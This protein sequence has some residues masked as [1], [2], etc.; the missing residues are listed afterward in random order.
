MDTDPEFESIAL[1]PPRRLGRLLT[2]ARATAGFTLEDV[3]LRCGPAISLS[4]LASIERGTRVVDDR[5]LQVLVDAYGLA[6][7]SLV[8]PR[9]RLIV[10]LD[11]GILEVDGR[12]EPIGPVDV[13]R[14]E[15]LS[16]YLT[17][18][19]SMR[20]TTPG[21]PVPLRVEDLE[22]LGRVLRTGPGA[23]QAD[24]EALMSRSGPVSQ[25][26]GLLSRKVLV[27]AAGVLVALLGAGAL[28]LV[29]GSAATAQG[30]TGAATTTTTSVTANASSTDPGVRIGTAAVQSRQP[31]GAPGPV[32]ERTGPDVGS[33]G[34][35]TGTD[36]PVRLIPPATLER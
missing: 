1:V 20:E 12:R 19:Y 34:L 17:L 3:A 16:R 13:S 28:V 14:D 11:G 6:S 21:R 7:Q 33:G 15:V 22:T 36:V 23:I 32:V 30:N 18:V 27:P 35:V 8:P 5:E 2:E 24:L 25:R 26:Y 4:G 29:D 10:D 9:S 31:S